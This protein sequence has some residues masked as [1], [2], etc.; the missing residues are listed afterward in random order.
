MPETRSTAQ[1]RSK[2]KAGPEAPGPRTDHHTTDGIGQVPASA[3][4]RSESPAPAASPVVAFFQDLFSGSDRK[5]TASSTEPEASALPDPAAADPPASAESDQTAGAGSAETLDEPAVLDPQPSSDSNPPAHAISPSETHVVNQGVGSII[6]P[7]VENASCKA[8]VASTVSAPASAGDD[9]DLSRL[10][11]EAQVL[12]MIH[13]LH[14]QQL[15]AMHALVEGSQQC[16]RKEMY[17]AL[18]EASARQGPIPGPEP[19][20]DFSDANDS[21]AAGNDGTKY[22]TP[23]SSKE[24]DSPPQNSCTASS[25]APTAG[26][27][28]CALVALVR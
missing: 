20:E 5:A 14:E 18:A 9:A 2:T 15:A 27:V 22:S 17:A 23:S 12:S 1:T 8:N 21:D 4:A 25:S 7:S 16:M 6:S 26:R 3:G 11:H 28:V 10:A 19:Y 13:Q 24:S